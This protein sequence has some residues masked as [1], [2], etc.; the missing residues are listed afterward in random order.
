ML[1]RT[2][3]RASAPKSY[4]LYTCVLLAD[5]NSLLRFDEHDVVIPLVVIEELDRQKTRMDEVGANAR[6][7]VRLLEELGASAHGGLAS[8][9]HLPTGGTVRIELNG[10]HS[11]RLPGVLDPST[12]DHR[13][14]STCLNIHDGGRDAV[15]VTKDAALRIK[16]A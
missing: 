12:P 15:L 9:K 10:I 1:Q 14:L 6:R 4:V 3:D 5:P 11:E 8:P 13:I 2:H 7:A 16:G